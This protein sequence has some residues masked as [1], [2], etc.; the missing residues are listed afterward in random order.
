MLSVRDVSVRFDGVTALMGITLDVQEGEIVAI[1]G[2]NGAGKSTLLRAVVG[3]A[4]CSSGSISFNGESLKGLSTEEIVRRGIS[5]VP[6]TREL[7]P[8]MSC[9]DNLRTGLL[10]NRRDTRYEELSAGVYRLFPR[11]KEREHQR[12]GTL[13]GGEQQMLAIG[14]ALMQEPRLLLL[15]E[16]SLGLSPGLTSH[17]L[18]RI[19]EI[20]SRGRTV[21]LVEQKARLALEMA[22]RAHVLTVGRITHAGL[23]SELRHDETVRRLYFGEDAIMEERGD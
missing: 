18:E 12:A 15:D 2:A 21:V 4:R 16:P 23:A 11:L 10:T 13:S 7:F 19:R 5:L 17:L 9:R 8:Q 1:V 3:L 6:E 20:R 14:R 22:D